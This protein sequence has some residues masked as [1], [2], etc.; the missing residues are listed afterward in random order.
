[1]GHGAWNYVKLKSSHLGGYSGA[2]IRR[3]WGRNAVG[4]DRNASLS[5]DRV[6]EENLYIFSFMTN[7]FLQPL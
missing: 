3:F 6:E 7:I 5:T 4:K 2:K 1:M